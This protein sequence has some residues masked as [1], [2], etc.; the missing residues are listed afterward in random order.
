MKVTSTCTQLI[1]SH[2]ATDMLTT[3]NA[4]AQPIITEAAK[5]E[6]KPKKGDSHRESLNANYV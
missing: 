4:S 6:E 1:Q 3:I 5:P 2:N